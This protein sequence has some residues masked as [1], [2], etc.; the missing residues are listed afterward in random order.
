MLILLKLTVT[1]ILVALVSIAARRWGPTI[2]GLIMGLPW[3]TGPILSSSASNE[4][5]HTWPAPQPASL[6]A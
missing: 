1:P 5:K 4:A 6:R 3:M 2:G